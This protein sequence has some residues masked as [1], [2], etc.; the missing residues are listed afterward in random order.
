LGRTDGRWIVV[1]GFANPEDDKANRR[2]GHRPTCIRSRNSCYSYHAAY[3]F[4]AAQEQDHNSPVGTF[5]GWQA[6]LKSICCI[7]AVSK[8]GKRT[9][10]AIHF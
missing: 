6:F 3:I 7:E 4:I 9:P 5:N 1:V 8:T 10:P 2:H